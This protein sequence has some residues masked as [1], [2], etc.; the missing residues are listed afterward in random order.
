MV[1]CRERRGGVTSCCVSEDGQFSL[2]T[3][4]DGAAIL[5]RLPAMTRA[6]LLRASSGVLSG[7]LHPNNVH[8][9]LL[10]SDNRSR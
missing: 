6:H 5:W 10:S 3:A 2:T 7:K 1:L 9:L 8:A 4:S